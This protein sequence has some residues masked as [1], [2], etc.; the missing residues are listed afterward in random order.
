MERVAIFIDAAN[1]IGAQ[2]DN[3]WDIDYKK[4]YEYFR[5]DKELTVACYFTGTPHYEQAQRIEKHR[6]FR[7]F[8]FSTGYTVVEKEVRKIKHKIPKDIL[9]NGKEVTDII[10]EETERQGSTPKEIIIPNA[11]V[12]LYKGEEKKANLDVE[13]ALT[14]I[15]EMGHYDRAIFL[16][17]DGDFEPL[18]SFLRNN[19]KYIVCV[20]RKQSTSFLLKNIAHKFIDLND[21]RAEI[22]KGDS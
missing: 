19:G 21:I 13:I 16:S 10:N 18:L 2:K 14:M 17:G 20:A 6:G 8:L 9:V 4:A 1:M 12:K 15:A 22:E 3:H 11:D 5:K 7:T